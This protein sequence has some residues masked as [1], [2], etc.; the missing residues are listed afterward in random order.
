M[1]ISIEK[2]RRVRD[3]Y[4][5]VYDSDGGG[6]GCCLHIVLDDGNIQDDHVQY[7][8]EK[9]RLANHPNCVALAEA[10]LSMSKTQ[11][12]KLGRHGYDNLP[13]SKEEQEVQR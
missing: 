4:Y 13:L 6:A 1:K 2:L 7:C 3:L 12:L 9:A 10:L 8:L 11:R 5:A